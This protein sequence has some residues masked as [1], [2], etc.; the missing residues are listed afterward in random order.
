MSELKKD[1][2][3][4]AVKSTEIKDAM[5]DVVRSTTEPIISMKKLAAAG[6][7]YGHQMRKWN[8]KM[9][10]F[11]YTSDRGIYIVDLKK[12][13]TKIEEAYNKLKEI[14][15][16][17]GTVLFVGTKKQIQAV[18]KE[19]ALRSGSFYINTR[20]LGGTLTNFRTILGRIRYLK[21]LE[22][23]EASG[24]LD[25][26]PKKEAG[27]LRKMKDKLL[28]NLE[29]I[30]EIRGLPKAV[31]VVDPTVD[32]NAVA[33]ARKLNIPVFAITD[34]NCDP[35]LVD[36]PIPGNDDAIG[37]V[38][39]IV[40]TIADAIVEAK[41]GVTVVA[42]TKDDEFIAKIAALKEATKPQDRSYG[43]RQDYHRSSSSSSYNS[44]SSTVPTATPSATVTA[45]TTMTPAA[46][47]TKPVVAPVAAP[48]PVVAPVA[49]T[50]PVAAPVTTAK[51][52]ATP[53]TAAKPAATPVPATKSAPVTTP[54]AAV[55]VEEN[56]DKKP[57]AARKPKIE[58]K[59][60]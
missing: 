45:T 32:H 19:E 34:T 8:P 5:A 42:Y 20:W 29:G 53:V 37:S 26:L 22:Q 51:P 59:E 13:V 56:T 25:L 55:K 60:E 38:R 16:N 28:K 30:K 18:I 27:G 2:A 41:G 11:I 14:I 46:P 7:Q 21:D 3:L 44:T 43:P 54:V 6:V 50:K 49:P 57:R 17:K 15:T 48:K 47:V 58:A 33:E 35:D 36:Y 12:T 24:T 10:K 31:F 40:Q 52:A 23:Q 1:S 4:P 39:L 9:A